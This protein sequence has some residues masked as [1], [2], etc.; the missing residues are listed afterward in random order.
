[1]EP[2]IATVKAALA[3]LNGS[4]PDMEKLLAVAVLLLKA[5]PTQ[6]LHTNDIWPTPGGSIDPSRHREGLRRGDDVR[7]ELAAATY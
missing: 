2:D 1:M 6:Q 5:L 7:A 4:V 3:I